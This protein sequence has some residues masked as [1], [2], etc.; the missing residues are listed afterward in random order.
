MAQFQLIL[1]FKLVQQTQKENT[2]IAQVF[3]VIIFLLSEWISI[4]AEHG[5]VFL[6]DN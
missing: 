4:Q 2:L 5:N 6:I 3:Q 1:S